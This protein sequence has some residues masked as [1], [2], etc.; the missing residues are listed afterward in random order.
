MDAGVGVSAAD[1]APVEDWEVRWGVATP[2]MDGALEVCGVVCERAEL[3]DVVRV[4]DDPG[5]VVRDGCQQMKKGRENI[6]AEEKTTRKRDGK[7]THGWRTS[8][9][10]NHRQRL[11]LRAYM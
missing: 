5:T 9:P 4:V 7:A 6:K 11:D 2:V 3:A 8:D 10:T 1:G